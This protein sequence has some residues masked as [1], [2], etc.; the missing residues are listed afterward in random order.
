MAA[1][2][3][4]PR[5][6]A[7]RDTWVVKVGGSLHTL[8]RGRANR[9]EANRAFRRLMAER[10]ERAARGGPEGGPEPTVGLVVA[11][12]LA[13]VKARSAGG[14]M[15]ARTHGDYSGRLADFA[16]RLGDLRADELA[17]RHVSE[18]AASK[19]GAWGANRRGDAIAVVLTAFRWAK[20][21]GLIRV[22]PLADGVPKPRRKLR[23]DRIPTR[24]EVAR[25][26]AAIDRPEFR[27]F[28]EFCGLTG[29][30]PGEAARIEAAHLDREKGVARL[31]EHKTARK[32]YRPRII[33][34]VGRAA[35]IAEA[36][37]AAR[38][39]GPIFLNAR[40]NPWERSAW[41]NRVHAARAAAGLDPRIVLYSFRHAWFTEGLRATGDLAGMAAAGGHADPSTTARVYNFV[42]EDYAHLRALA[43][44]AAG[45]APSPAPAPPASPGPAPGEGTSSGVPHAGPPPSP[46]GAPPAPARRGGR[47]RSP[48]R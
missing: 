6:R 18:W 33:P 43:E 22:N 2:P 3:K 40:G 4:G 16:D 19:G 8:A 48:P 37:A 47:R 1:Q 13:D 5:Y 10:D 23:R 14:E 32:T 41:R 30:R 36:L 44:K 24:E 11:R 42:H 29:C 25:F 15:A 7:D 12:F 46:A 17:P 31:P 45:S 35:E 26:L 9:A 39:T 28:A 27:A 38:P 20:R 21:Q 34:L